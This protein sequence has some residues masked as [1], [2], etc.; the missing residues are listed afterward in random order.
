M[1]R[2]A[3]HC[4]CASI[5][6]QQTLALRHSVLWPDAPVSHVPLPEDECGWHFGAFVDPDGDPVAVLS[7]FLEPL[8]IDSASGPRDYSDG[9]R[10]IARFRKFACDPDHQGRGIGT[11]LL[12]HMRRFAQSDLNATVIWCDARASTSAWYERRGM[13]TFGEKFYKGSIEY[14]RMK[15]DLEEATKLQKLP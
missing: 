1:N 15:M 6:V 5:T 12:Q 8:P 7:L 13:K 14:I 3:P 10:P 4:Y 11:K 9:V 2:L